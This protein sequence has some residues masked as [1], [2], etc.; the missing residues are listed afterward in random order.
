MQALCGILLVLL[1]SGLSAVQQEWARQFGGNGYSYM[2]KM[3]VD[4]KTAALFTVSNTNEELTMSVHVDRWHANGTLLWSQTPLDSTQ[5]NALFVGIMDISAVNSIYLTPYTVIDN[6]VA[7]NLTKLDLDGVEVWSSP[8]V[9]DV[10]YAYYSYLIAPYW[11][12]HHVFVL[13]SFDDQPTDVNTLDLALVKLDQSTGKQLWTK[14]YGFATYS[15]A[16]DIAV[17]THHHTVYI[18]GIITDDMPNVANPGVRRV[19]LIAV[20]ADTGKVKWQHLVSSTGGRSGR[21]VGITVD[22]RT[23]DVYI[24]GETD[25]SIGDDV[26]DAFVVKYD[27]NGEFKWARLVGGS[28]DDDATAIEINEH[29]N[30]VIVMGT[31][32]GGFGGQTNGLDGSISPVTFMTTLDLEGNKHGTILLPVMIDQVAVH[33][34]TG[35]VYA[36]GSVHKDD[37]DR[38]DF[39][40]L[41]LKNPS[42]THLRG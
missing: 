13:Y 6:M 37:T 38:K 36:G 10:P 22:S 20:D 24:A 9:S 27:F 32:Y 35:D 26:R 8:L 2:T 25:G 41:I 29:S 1:G 40:A 15:Q 14:H 16:V 23:G 33:Q 3:A 39:D 28:G 11:P 5:N 34:R 12:S 42:S 7:V 4:E 21:P 31:T 18:C 19:G 17:D 30:Q